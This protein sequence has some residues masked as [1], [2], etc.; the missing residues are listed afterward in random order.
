MCVGERAGRAE[1]CT[2]LGG[3]LADVAVA[4]AFLTKNRMMLSAFLLVDVVP[5]AA[6]PSIS[7]CPR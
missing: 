1:G 3:P 7:C 4:P 6:L 2:Y 5:A